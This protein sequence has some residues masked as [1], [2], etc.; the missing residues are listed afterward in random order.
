MASGVS[1]S[2]ELEHGGINYIAE[3]VTKF[4]SA[5]EQVLSKYRGINLGARVSSLDIPRLEILVSIR[6]TDPNSDLA[7]AVTEY[8]SLVGAPDYVRGGSDYGVVEQALAPLEKTLRRPILAVATL[9]SG[10]KVVRRGSL[11]QLA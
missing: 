3:Q 11:P 2:Y 5:G 9:H 10:K 7:G 8:F 6:E 4:K 1:L